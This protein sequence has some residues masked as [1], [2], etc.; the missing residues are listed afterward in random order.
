[1]ARLHPIGS[2]QGEEERARAHLT[3][4][5]PPVSPR[6]DAAPDDARRIPFAEATCRVRAREGDG[7]SGTVLDQ[8]SSLAAAVLTTD[9]SESLATDTF[10]IVP[11]EPP[12][13][14]RN[15]ARRQTT[16]GS[17]RGS[18]TQFQAGPGG[19]SKSVLDPKRPI[20]EGMRRLGEAAAEPSRSWVRGRGNARKAP[21]THYFFDPLTLTLSP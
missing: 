20:T 15:P 8:A 16:R 11:T 4:D 14:R 6:R 2:R 5:D 18:R 3:V 12:P 21:L 10:G 9:G 1:M 7:H 19:C 13:G 17:H